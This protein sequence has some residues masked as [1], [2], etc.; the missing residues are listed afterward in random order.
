MNMLNKYKWY[1]IAIIVLVL[2]EV[3]LVGVIGVWREYFWDAVEKKQL[4]SFMVL[5]AVFLVAAL[6]AC[7]VSGYTQYL[8]SYVSLLIRA[9][10]TEIA[11]KTDY[12]GIEGHEQ[13]IQE[14]CYNYQFYGITLLVNVLRNVLILG[15]FVA[16]TIIQVGSIYLILPTLYVIIPTLFAY[17]IARPLINLNYMN[18]CLEAGLRKSI[19][20][21]YYSQF[22]YNQ[23]FDN[24]KDLFHATKRL[25]YFQSFYNQITVV[26]PYLLMFSIYFSGKITFGIFM[27][28][29]GSISHI[30]GALSYLI[31]SFDSFNQFLSCQKRLKEMGVIK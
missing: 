4:Y 21:K 20:N 19:L 24:N 14:D 3:V 9:D 18:Q 5:M 15:T 23:V 8:I 7:V 13:R 11:L 12:T 17:Y 10:Y 6:I 29:A 1:F 31:N 25:T 22:I 28:V 30:I 27:Q 2:I 26:I 16:L